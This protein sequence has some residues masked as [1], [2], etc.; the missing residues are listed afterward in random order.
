MEPPTDSTAQRASATYRL[1]VEDI[2][3]LQRDEMRPIRLALEYAKVA[4]CA[5]G[6][7]HPLHHHRVR[8]RPRAVART[9]GANCRRT[10]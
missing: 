2:D 7:G 10:T 6:L 4:L 5:A 3:F 8:Q 9:A 1:A